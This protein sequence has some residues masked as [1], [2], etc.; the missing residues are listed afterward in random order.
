M[1]CRVCGA[2]TRETFGVH[3]VN[4]RWLLLKADYCYW[5]G[6]FVTPQALASGIEVTPDPTVR[7]HIRPGLHVL[8]Y[9]KEHQKIQQYTEGFVGSILTNSLVHNRGI[10]VRL[11]DGRVGRIQKILV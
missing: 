8:I 7:E 11:T 5:H 3:Y 2:N 1:K 6:S 4:G 9:L 10:K